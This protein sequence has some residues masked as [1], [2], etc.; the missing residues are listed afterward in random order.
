MLPP[1]YIE[2]SAVSDDGYED[3]NLQKLFIEAF[4]RLLK[5]LRL[6]IERASRP[7][8]V[9]QSVS[10]PLVCCGAIAPTSTRR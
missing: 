6:P 3:E 9:R 10:G 4:R 2:I 8:D 1:C 7:G 5:R